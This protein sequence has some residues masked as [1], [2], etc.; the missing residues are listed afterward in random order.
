MFLRAGIIFVSLDIVYR[1]FSFRGTTTQICIALS[2]CFMGISDCFSNLFSRRWQVRCIAARYV[3]SKHDIPLLI[4]FSCSFPHVSSDINVLFFGTLAFAF[5]VNVCAY[6][7]ISYQRKKRYRNRFFTKTNQNREQELNSEIATLLDT[8]E[9]V[10][11]VA[12]EAAS[13]SNKLARY[14]LVFLICTTFSFIEK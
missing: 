13:T 10:G 12:G 5:L 4:S 3:T 8:S 14:C 9:P 1:A 6:V 2:L 7:Q 11:R